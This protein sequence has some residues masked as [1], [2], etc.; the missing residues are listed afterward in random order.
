MLLGGAAHGFDEAA[1][2]FWIELVCGAAFEFGE[3]FFGV[4]RFLVGA[5]GRDGVVGVGDGDDAR[6]EGNLIA[7]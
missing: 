4:A 2:D 6:A 7:R 5:L 1:D 3:S